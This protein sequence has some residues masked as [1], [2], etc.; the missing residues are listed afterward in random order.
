[1]TDTAKLNN[2]DIEFIKAMRF[3][4]E[5]EMDDEF[6]SELLM[7]LEQGIEFLRKKRGEGDG[8]KSADVWSDWERQKLEIDNIED[9]V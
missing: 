5:E 8:R 6:K 9:L 3:S 2:E 7:E 1:M 4:I